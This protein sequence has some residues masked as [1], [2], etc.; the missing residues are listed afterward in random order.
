MCGRYGLNHRRDQIEDFFAVEIPAPYA[1]RYNIAPTQPVLII[2]ENPHKPG[3]LEAT[4]VVW[5]LIPPWADDIRIGQKMINARCETAG[6][7][8]SFRHALKRRRC[9]VPISGFYE[10]QRVGAAPTGPKQPYYIT[11]ADGNPLALGGL[12]EIWDGPNGE[13]IESCTILTTTANQSLSAMHDRMPVIIPAPSIPTWLD[14]RNEEVRSLSHFLNPAPMET[15]NIRPIS[16]MVNSVRN[17][18][19]QLIAQELF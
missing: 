18:G 3:G 7:K 16:T 19:P 15:L 9:I 14:T 4:H 6:E 1:P 10:W 12:W 8:P 11:A 2:R 17:D 13:Q 5:G